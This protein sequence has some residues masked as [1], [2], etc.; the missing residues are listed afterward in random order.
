[1]IS[2][3]WRGTARPEEADNYI[4]HLRQDT[5]PKLT[6]LEG[7]ISASILRRPT[8]QGVEFLIVTLWQSIEAVRRFAGDEAE[9]AVVPAVV[10]AM[11]VDYDRE[12]THYEVVDAYKS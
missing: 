6:E 3:N 10:Q 4:A 9:V 2:R 11:M 1:M 8:A 5:F 12:V 7:F